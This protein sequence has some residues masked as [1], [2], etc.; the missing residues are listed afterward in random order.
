MT[1][2]TRSAVRL[3]IYLGEDKRAGDRPLC[4]AIIQEARRLGLAGATVLRGTQGFGRSTRL[5][6]DEVLFSD[7]LPVVIEIIDRADRADAFARSLASLTGIG[8]IT[9]ETVAL[10]DD[11]HPTKLD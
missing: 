4:K 6:T 5:H 3:R 7:D 2:G 9:R 10:A 8:L 11:R 1:E